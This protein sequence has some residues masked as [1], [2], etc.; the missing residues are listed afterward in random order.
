MT[1]GLNVLFSSS[2]RRSTS[3]FSPSRTTYC[4]PPS[5]MIAY[6]AMGKRRRGLRVGQSTS[7]VSS[8]HAGEAGM[9]SDG[10]RRLL[11]ALARH[12]GEAG[13]ASDGR[14][15]LLGALALRR[16]RLSRLGRLLLTAAAAARPAAC[17]LLRRFLCRLLGLSLFLGDRLFL[18]DRL[19]FRD[20]L[21]CRG[22]G[23]RRLRLRRARSARPGGL[24]RLRL[25]SDRRPRLGTRS[26][27]ELGVRRPVDDPLDPHLD[28]LPDHGRG[29][30]HADRQLAVLGDACAAIVEPDLDELDLA[31]LAL[32]ERALGLQLGDGPSLE[33]LEV[34]SGDVFPPGDEE[35]PARPLLDRLQPG[36]CGTDQD[37]RNVG[38]EFDSKGA[39]T[40][41]RGERAKLALGLDRRRRLGDDRAVAVTDGTA[42]REDLPWPVRDVLPGHLDQSEGGDL[43]DVRLRPVALELRLQRVLDRLAV[44]RVR[45][46][47]E[48]DDDDPADV[49][50]AQLTDNLFDRLEVVL[51]DRVLEPLAG[52]LRA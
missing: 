25:R 28:A 18:R 47:D 17:L 16:L 31:L 13:M 14:R 48:V 12:A 42:L 26:R 20:R 10:R 3:S 15:R 50:E 44:L 19:V 8:G 2:A 30:R 1:S 6:P 35:P 29:I 23:R 52:A 37:R 32:L 51:R 9:A 41:L 22:R 46:V 49:P 24:L 34:V 39:R 38:V 21:L 27:D 36:G 4:L 7:G 40:R 43:D 33:L 11:G 5:L 45:H